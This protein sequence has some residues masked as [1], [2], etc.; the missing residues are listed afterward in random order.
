MDT[1]RFARF[2]RPGHAV[3][4][5]RSR[6][7]AQMRE[8]VGYEFAHSIV[9][10]HSRLAFTEPHLDERG[11]TVVEFMERALAFFRAHGIEPKRLQTDNAWTYTKNRAL[12]D[13][14]RR[15]G[16]AHRTIP[17]RMPK[18]NGKVERYQ[19]TLKRE[20]AWGSAT[21][22][23]SIGQEPCHTGFTTTTTPDATAQSATGLRSVAFGTS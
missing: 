1:K 20:W 12:A 23:Q 13:P 11:S 7:G 5:N 15:E 10:E 21:A 14:L 6:T 8:Q 17:P 22:P 19:Q 16:I 2:R 9:D 3:T 18:R 4:G